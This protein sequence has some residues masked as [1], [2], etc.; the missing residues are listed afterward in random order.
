MK[1]SKTDNIPSLT[2]LENSLFSNGTIKIDNIEL[3]SNSL[4]NPDKLIQKVFLDIS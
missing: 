1:L 2:A 3:N 4:I